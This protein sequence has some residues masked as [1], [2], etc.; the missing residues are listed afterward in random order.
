[1]TDSEV[2][3]FFVHY[4]LTRNPEIRIFPSEFCTMSGD[5][6]ELGKPNLARMSLIEGY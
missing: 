4:R 5:W 1:M 3:T 2:M 6:G